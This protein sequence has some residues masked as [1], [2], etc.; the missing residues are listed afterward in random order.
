MVDLFVNGQAIMPFTGYMLGKVRRQ[1]AFN[2]F[3]R[4]SFATASEKTQTQ[5][6]LGSSQ[7]RLMF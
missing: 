5:P 2:S 4:T 3:K 6:I 1:T 7:L